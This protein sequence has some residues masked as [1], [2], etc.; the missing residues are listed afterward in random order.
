[1]GLAKFTIILKKKVQAL[2][3]SAHYF[4]SKCVVFM[5]TTK[6]NNHILEPRHNIDDIPINFLQYKN[7]PPLL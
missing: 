4:T 2:A 1:M 6:T 7:R 5:K 3:S